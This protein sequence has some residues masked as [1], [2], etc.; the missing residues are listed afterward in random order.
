RLPP[1]GHLGA[2]PFAESEDL[3]GSRD[4]E[5]A[6]GRRMRSARSAFDECGAE[7]AFEV[8]QMMIDR[9]LA[10]LQVRSRRGHGSG[11]RDGAQSG[12]LAS[13]QR[14]HCSPL[15]SSILTIEQSR[16]VAILLALLASL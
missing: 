9:R 14:F 4:D 10:P 3:H 2:E 7:A 6:H 12:E 15:S 16:K 1:Q 11:R 5:A 13:V 8:A